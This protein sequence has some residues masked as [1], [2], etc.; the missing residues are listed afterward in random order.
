M[1]KTSLKHY[2]I[3][4]VFN[5]M[6][7]KKIIASYVGPFYNDI[8]ALLAESMQKSLWQNES[9]RRR[10]FRI[11]IE[12][13][14]NVAN[15]SQERSWLK[16]KS[17]GEGTF[18]LS[19]YGK[20]FLF[21]AGNVVNDEIK[22]MLE[23]RVNEINKLDRLELRALKRKLRKEGNNKGGG[24]IGLTQVALLSKNK[25]NVFFQKIDDKKYFYMISIK[26]EKF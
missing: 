22:E 11:F 19:D 12:L 21:S 15:Y 26:I 13:S 25:L 18:I 9:L 3:L 17:Y 4:S 20:F 5:I 23:K 10:F 8:L 2:D 24:N 7:E 1:L 14:Q 6:F 16:G